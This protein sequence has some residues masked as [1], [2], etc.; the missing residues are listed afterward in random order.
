MLWTVVFKGLQHEIFQAYRNAVGK[1]LFI[2][3][4]SYQLYFVYEYM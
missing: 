2:L 4:A 1:K 3:Y